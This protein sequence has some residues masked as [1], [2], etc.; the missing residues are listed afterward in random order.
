MADFSERIMARDIWTHG[1]NN[2]HL[3]V[4]QTSLLSLL[5]RN[6][7]GKPISLASP[8]ITNLCL[9]DNRLGDFAD[10]FPDEPNKSWILLSDYLRRL[11][12]HAEI[13]IITL[14]NL[15]SRN[16][17]YGLD[18]QK[19]RTI[20]TKYAEDEFHEKGILAPYF[21]IEGSM[22]LTSQGLT[23]RG[24]KVIY[25]AEINN[26]RSSKISIAYLE[27]NRHWDNLS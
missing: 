6:D 11:S 14:N 23:K 16:F 26:I 20:K 12:N 7:I 21:Y 10:L 13:R 8:W 24:E 17:I 27:F 18:T 25:H 1:E 15:R 2:G 19:N 9:I 3:G 4:I 22:N 5:L